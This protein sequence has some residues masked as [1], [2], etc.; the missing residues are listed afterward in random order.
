MFMATVVF[1]ILGGP[2]SPLVFLWIPNG[3]I[4]EGFNRVK[5]NHCMYAVDMY[6]APD[7]DVPAAFTLRGRVHPMW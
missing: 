4:Q 6:V 3:L 7:M 1:K 2:P 5:L